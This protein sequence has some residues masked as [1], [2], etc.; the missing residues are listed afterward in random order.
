MPPGTDFVP[1]FALY[2]SSAFR[3]QDKLKP[4]ET[5]GKAYF[6]V[7]IYT[8]LITSNEEETAASD[9]SWYSAPCP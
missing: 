2:D 3:W 1:V 4:G 5:C 6:V 8:D 7:A 9:T